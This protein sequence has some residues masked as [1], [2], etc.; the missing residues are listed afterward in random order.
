MLSE[1]GRTRVAIIIIDDDQILLIH[2]YKY[3]REYYIIPGGG[4]ESGESLEQAALREAKEETGLAVVLDRKLWAYTN[5][6]RPEHYFLAA[7]FSG[8]LG[9]GGPE[10][11]EQ[12]AENIYQLEWVRLN[13]LKA[14][15]LLPE[16]IKEKIIDELR[17]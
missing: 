9:L 11:V 4:V 6:G 12:S 13:D 17:E 5:N 10:L 2:R 1:P 8:N 14:L 15:P 3:G 16:F 7:R